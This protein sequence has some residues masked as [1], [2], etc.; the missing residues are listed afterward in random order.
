MEKTKAKVE[1]NVNDIA[2]ELIRL[3]QERAQSKGFQFSP[4]TEMQEA[5]EARFP[6]EPTPDQLASVHEIK[7]DMEDPKPMD[8]LLC[9]DVGYGK[10]EVAIRAAFKAVQDGKQVAFLVPTTILA[11]Q[12]FESL[13][14]RIED[15]PVNVAMMSRFRTAKENRETAEGLKEGRID[16]VV[17]TH[18]ILGKSIEYKDLGLLIVD[19]EQRFGVKHKEAIKQMKIMSMC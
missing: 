4:D 3:Y 10:T 11:A 1:A 17:G 7:K 19:E 6:Y 9:G 12:H 16:I 14:E 8:R 15:Y 13:I 5:F 2:E 18:K